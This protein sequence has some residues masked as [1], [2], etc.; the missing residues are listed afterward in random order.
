MRHIYFPRRIRPNYSRWTIQSALWFDRIVCFQVVKKSVTGLRLLAALYT[1]RASL[2]CFLPF[3]QATDPLYWSAAGWRKEKVGSRGG[4]V[5]Y[6][7]IVINWRQ[8][9][10]RSG[11][12]TVFSAKCKVFWNGVWRIHTDIS[13]LEFSLHKILYL[14]I[15]DDILMYISVSDYCKVFRFRLSRLYNSCTYFAPFC[16]FSPNE[17]RYV[18]MSYISNESCTSWWR[19]ASSSSFSTTLGTPEAYIFVMLM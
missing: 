5:V 10:S 2:L 13:W 7:Y 1:R 19:T 12:Y 6:Y 14:V 11:E 18:C 15:Y 9:L 8:I 16:P 4:L 3:G 17:E